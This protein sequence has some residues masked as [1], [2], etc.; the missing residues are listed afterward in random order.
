MILTMICYTFII[1]IIIYIIFS[2]V[3]YTSFYYVPIV[4]NDERTFVDFS[5]SGPKQYHINKDRLCIYENYRKFNCYIALNS[6]ITSL[7]DYGRTVECT[8]PDGFEI[9]T[10][11]DWYIFYIEKEGRYYMKKTLPYEL[12]YE[13]RSLPYEFD[14][15]EIFMT[16]KLISIVKIVIMALLWYDFHEKIYHVELTYSYYIVWAVTCMCEVVYVIIIMKGQ[17]I[18]FWNVSMCL[19]T[20]IFDFAPIYLGYMF[21]QFRGNKTKTDEIDEIDEMV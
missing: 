3:I 1:P 17:S 21:G 9:C 18:N 6:E 5:L 4:N 14:M 8:Y 20:F 2:P 13:F 19:S 16:Q 12:E 11:R 10:F 7:F 15:H